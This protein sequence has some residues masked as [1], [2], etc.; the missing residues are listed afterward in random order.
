VNFYFVALQ[1]PLAKDFFHER[2]I[3]CNMDTMYYLENNELFMRSRAAVKI[4][5]NLR[6]P[7]TVFSKILGILPVKLGDFFYNI[8]A[9]NRK[10]IFRNKCYLPNQNE[11]SFFIET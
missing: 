10:K 6:F 4:G 5:T 9:R 3:I 7:Y 1:S 2:G 11:R 8:V